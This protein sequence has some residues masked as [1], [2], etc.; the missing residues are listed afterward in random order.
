MRRIL[1]L[2]LGLLACSPRP[3]ELLLPL[4]DIRPPSVLDAGQTDAQNYSILFD[5][6]ILPVMASFAFSPAGI[7]ATPSAEGPLL[8]VGLDPEAEPGRACSL[9]GEVKDSAGNSTRFLFDFVGYNPVPARLRL[10]EV[11]PGKNTSASNFHRDYVELLVQ[12]EGNLGGIQ[13]QW[14]STVKLASYTFPPCYVKAGELIV[15]HCSPE[16]IP[17][18]KDE[19][20]DDLGLSE[21]VDANSRGR[22]FWASSGGIPDATG[23][24]ILR[25][26]TSGPVEDG[27]FFAEEEKAGEVDAS[28]ISAILDEMASRDIWECSTPT[29][30]EDALRWKNSS[31]KPLHRLSAAP[32]GKEAWYVGESGSQSPGSLEPRTLASKSGG[33]IGRQGSP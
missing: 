2:C 27:L 19:C 16:G 26:R 11:Q 4:G 9:F 17:Q 8:R 14:A 33:K 31:S 5:E 30:W 24:I 7:T 18:E 32:K 15:L 25:N 22:D 20:D 1:V 12:E 3:A 28:K 13:L 6:E 21:G 10:N 29:L 23:V